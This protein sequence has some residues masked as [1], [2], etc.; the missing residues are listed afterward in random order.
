MAELEGDIQALV[1]VPQ[2]VCRVLAPPGPSMLSS[3]LGSKV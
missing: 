3:A 2:H 1:T